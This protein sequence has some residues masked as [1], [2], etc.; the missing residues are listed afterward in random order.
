MLRHTLG[1]GL[2]GMH[3]KHILSEKD[4]DGNTALHLSAENGLEE[5]VQVK[6]GRQEGL[7]LSVEVRIDFPFTHPKQG[8]NYLTISS[9]VVFLF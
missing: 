8:L 4:I 1:V 3:L 9:L 7:A 2:Y 6:Q 5:C